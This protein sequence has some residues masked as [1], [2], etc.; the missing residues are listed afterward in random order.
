MG[1]PEWFL[2]I[3]SRTNQ[4]LH[5]GA[6]IAF[7]VHFKGPKAHQLEQDF[8]RLIV[9][10]RLEEPS[11]FIPGYYNT[12]RKKRLG[13]RTCSVR[14]PNEKDSKITI[15]ISCDKLLINLLAFRKKEIQIY[16]LQQWLRRF[17]PKIFVSSVCCVIKDAYLMRLTMF[18]IML[19]K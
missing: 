16:K 6:C 8:S 13:Y 10:G 9:T 12:K 17:K 1:I 4:I 2:H 7:K 15:T 14:D 19:R 11:L 3:D 5:G 18:G